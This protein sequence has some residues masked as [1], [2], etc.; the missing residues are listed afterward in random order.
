MQV[1]RR[2]N[3]NV[4]ETGLRL[5]WHGN[6]ALEALK[7][8]EHLISVELEELELLSLPPG[9]KLNIRNNS[10]FTFFKANPTVQTNFC[11]SGLFDRLDEK[12]QEMSQR[13]RKRCELDW[14]PG[15]HSI[16]R[17]HVFI[18]QQRVIKSKSSARR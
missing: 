11:I 10:A 2:C 1:S 7:S 3:D 17:H 9:M 16:L 14:M 8:V 15:C 12:L 13:R 6:P 18:N 5:E 4:S